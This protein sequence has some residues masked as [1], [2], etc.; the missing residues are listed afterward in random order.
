M[1]TQLGARSVRHPSFAERVAARLSCVIK[2]QAAAPLFGPLWQDPSAVEITRADAPDAL[3]RA[4][5]RR[6]ELI[7][8]HTPPEMKYLG[9]ILCDATL[10]TALFCEAFGPHCT[11]LDVY[12]AG[13]EPETVGEADVYS[14]ERTAAF[15]DEFVSAI[16]ILPGKAKSSAA[17]FIS[18]GI[19]D[20]L[21]SVRYVSTQLFKI[22]AAGT[23][24]ELDLVECLVAL[25]VL[26]ALPHC[27]VVAPVEIRLWLY[28]NPAAAVAQLA[29][30]VKSKVL[31][32]LLVEFVSAA[33]ERWPVLDRALAKTTEHETTA[34]FRFKVVNNDAKLRGDMFALIRYHILESEPRPGKPP[35]SGR[36]NV[37]S[38]SV[39]CV[40]ISS[41]YENALSTYGIKRKLSSKTIA[42]IGPR[43][44]GLYRAVVERAPHGRYID[45]DAMAQ[46][47]VPDTDAGRALYLHA[48]EQRS[49]GLV[50]VAT[51]PAV[52]RAQRRAVAA[53]RLTGTVEV[54]ARC[55]S[56]RDTPAGAKANKATGGTLLD[57]KTGS[58]QCANC[59]GVD[60]IVDIDPCGYWFVYIGRHI[61]RDRATAVVCAFCGAFSQAH[62]LRGN[63]PMCSAC[64]AAPDPAARCTVECAVCNAKMHRKT[65]RVEVLCKNERAID[66]SPRTASVCHTCSDLESLNRTWDLTMMRRYLGGK[67]RR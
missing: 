31:W 64:A 40:P 41:P 62:E 20:N 28:R 67:G 8:E 51:L 48:I 27:R 26:G 36:Y 35:K 34:P 18:K 63:L 42:E 46:L 13:K 2:D 1:R 49:V 38:D 15:L 47:G 6:A 10:R 5:V 11:L 9:G 3:F 25:S 66:G 54:C 33:I 57:V 7:M 45:L 24:A 32:L 4:L 43:F 14:V 23:K 29:K 21:S 12:R 19:L 58:R 44:A 56:L 53:A 17:R 52:E 16:S 61:D 60:A 39:R 30:Q 55:N 65:T 37:A 59:G 50:L 22:L